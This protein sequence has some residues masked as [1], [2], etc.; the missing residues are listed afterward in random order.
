MSARAYGWISVVALLLVGCGAA[1]L[2]PDAWASPSGEPAATSQ[3][4]GRALL[5]ELAAAH[6]GVDAWRAGTYTQ[7][8]VRDHWPHFVT[9]AAASPWPEAGQRVRFTVLSGQ[10]SIRAEFLDGPEKGT[11]W[12][13]QQWVT[14]TVPGGQTAPRFAPDSDIWF[15]LPTVAYF[16][17]A[18]FRL[19]EGQNV[20]Y[21]GSERLG[22]RA[23]EKVFVTWGGWQIDGQI[24]QYVAWIDAETRQLAYLQYTVRDFGASMQG[25]VA[26][27]GYTDAGGGLLAPGDVRTVDAP[28]ARDVSLHQMVFT[29]VDYAA[30]VPR[31][32]VVPDPSRSA[33]KG[34]GGEAR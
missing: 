10:D 29:Q 5:E 22:E 7:F 19:R 6:G 20:A 18:P 30:D 31:A 28:G 27:S 8:V 3:E 13:I 25:T 2:R 15:W 16:F 1:D 23:Y 11:A 34:D 9:R 14:Y 21:L 17:E 4:R 24:D 26:Y 33:S 32:F 12:G